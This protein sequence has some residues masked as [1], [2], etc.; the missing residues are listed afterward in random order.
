MSD[1]MNRQSFKQML[2]LV[3]KYM[4]RG[5]T[6]DIEFSR[7]GLTLKGVWDLSLSRYE[8][9][10]FNREYSW[11]FL[12][13]LSEEIDLEYLIDEFKEEFKEKYLIET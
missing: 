5:L 12:E 2:S 9:I 7:Y 6:I 11:R 4:N 1:F 10:H 13:E 8:I 3:N